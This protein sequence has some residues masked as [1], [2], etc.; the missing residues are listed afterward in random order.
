M[1]EKRVTI[2][3]QN[4]LTELCSHAGR[5]QDNGFSLYRGVLVVWDDD[6][7][8]RVLDVLDR[9]PVNVLEQLLAVYERKASISFLWD[10]AVPHGYTEYDPVD[11]E[12]GDGDLF[13][14]HNSFAREPRLLSR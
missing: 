12:P 14:I 11:L 10:K 4:D 7:D 9:M 3:Q 1:S 5:F 6:Y 8:V 13:H 2:L